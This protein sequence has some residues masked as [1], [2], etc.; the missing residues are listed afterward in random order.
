MFS[1]ETPDCPRG[2]IGP[3]S[4]ACPFGPLGPVVPSN[5]DFPGGPR[6]PALPSS[7]LGPVSP[8]GPCTP[9]TPGG[10]GWPVGHTSSV[11]LQSSIAAG[12]NCSKY[13]SS[14]SNISMVKLR[15]GNCSGVSLRFRTLEVAESSL[16]S[17]ISVIRVEKEIIY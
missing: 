14:L 3:G 17:F 11:E 1:S 5:P 4:P 7:P 16:V 8:G 10:P 2:P 15:S 12:F 6:S 13:L 9:G